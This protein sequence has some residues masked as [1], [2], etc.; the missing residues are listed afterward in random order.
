M[1]ESEKIDEVSALITAWFSGEYTMFDACTEEPEIAWQAI[2]K[3]SQ[4][5]LTDEQIGLLGSGPLET[6]IAWHGVDFIDRVID[7]ARRSP[8]FKHLLTMVCRRGM[9]DEMWRQILR[10][11]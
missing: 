10:I 2:I 4:R 3:I 6:L 8:R 7:E 11:R 9:P 1:K 5:E